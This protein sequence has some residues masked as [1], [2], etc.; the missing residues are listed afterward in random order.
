[1]NRGTPWSDTKQ[2]GLLRGKSDILVTYQLLRKSVESSRSVPSA[3]FPV[4]VRGSAARHTYLVSLRVWG[5]RRGPWK[6]AEP[7]LSRYRPRPPGRRD[8]GRVRPATGGSGP[9]GPAR[10]PQP[11][12]AAGAEGGCTAG[13]G[14]SAP[15]HVGA[16][17]QPRPL[18]GPTP[19]R[20]PPDP[21]PRPHAPAPARPPHAVAR[22]VLTEDAGPAAG[23]R[24][25]AAAGSPQLLWG[26]A[27]DGG[28]TSRSPFSFLQQQTGSASRSAA[29]PLPPGLTPRMRPSRLRVP[30]G[31][32]RPGLRAPVERRFRLSPRP[33][34]EA[35]MGTRSWARRLGVPPPRLRLLRFGYRAASAPLVSPGG[36]H[37]GDP[38][39]GVVGA[40]GSPW[41]RPPRP[42][43]SECGGLRAVGVRYRPAGHRARSACHFPGETTARVSCPLHT[44]VLPRAGSLP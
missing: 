31:S 36:P 28:G 33:P 19:D 41:T 8:A 30:E 3:R 37:T 7:G 29:H 35:G 12:P 15:P 40:M 5:R 27:G 44:C 42:G 23:R 11:P 4:S 20:R 10:R 43:T 16:H 9:R 32:G 2:A 21:P 39:G 38:R 34:G 22:T 14:P 1:M 13:P 6:Q 26:G 17:L 24:G 25:R 18:A